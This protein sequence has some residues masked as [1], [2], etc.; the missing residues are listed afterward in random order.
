[1][2]GIVGAFMLSKPTYQ[3]SGKIE[4]FIRQGLYVGGLRG[5]DSTGLYSIAR[6]DGSVSV[7]KNVV[8]G[9]IFVDQYNVDKH[10]DDVDDYRAIVC[11]HRKA[12]VSG[13]VNMAGAHPFSI[14]DITLVHNGSLVT[15][16]SLCEKS[17][18]V[19]SAAICA[20]LNERNTVEVLEDIDGSFCLVWHDMSTNSLHIA[21][22]SQRPLSVG[23]TDIPGC[24][25][26]ASEEGMLEWLCERTDIKLEKVETPLPNHL[27]SWSDGATS[28]TDYTSVKFD[29]YVSAY[30]K[31]GT[32]YTYP[33][34]KTYTKPASTQVTTQTQPYTTSREQVLKNKLGLS[35]G[36]E[37]QFVIVEAIHRTGDKRTV[38]L[39]GFSDE[40]DFEVIAYNVS[41][42]PDFTAD[43]WTNCLCSGKISG[44][45]HADGYPEWITL[46]VTD[47]QLLE[48]DY[49]DSK[50]PE[51]T[52]EGTPVETNKQ[53]AVMEGEAE[54]SGVWEE[55]RHDGSIASEYCTKGC[56]EICVDCLDKAMD[57][58]ANPIQP[59]VEAFNPPR[60]ITL[61][62]WDKLTSKGCADCTRA[63]DRPEST[64]WT[65]NG[66][67]LC[68]ACHYGWVGWENNYR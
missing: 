9:S 68:P 51:S 40:W 27:Y 63:L 58:I 22:N 43:R 55:A 13:S 49:D 17:Y 33:N 62:E 12:T 52:D 65:Y 48:E 60:M 53:T 4:K 30:A 45:S 50:Q 39:E 54:E 3:Q 16:H 18:L 15:H 41:N 10:L 36:D 47:V 64:Y 5:R 19:D 26:F 61:A 46:I 57:P 28:P 35:Y 31:N 24:M 7:I 14:G 29:P 32:V 25:V 59:M 2:C 1:M 38:N 11:H 44:V 66:E 6:D 42:P 8:D 34:Y 21:R 23:F 20:G 67:C 37:V 56:S